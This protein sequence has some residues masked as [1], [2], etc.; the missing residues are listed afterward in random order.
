MSDGDAKSVEIYLKRFSYHELEILGITLKQ[1]PLYL[2]SMMR[3]AEDRVENR[4]ITTVIKGNKG[5]LD[6][7]QIPDAEWLHSMSRREV[8]R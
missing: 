7:I 2:T 5:C 4:K 1:K 8:Y 3:M 6:M